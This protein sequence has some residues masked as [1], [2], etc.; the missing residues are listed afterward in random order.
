MTESTPLL[1]I[2]A[3][4]IGLAVGVAARQAGLQCV[5]LEKRNIVSTIERYPLG[6]TFFSTPERVEIGGLPFIAL[7]VT[8]RLLVRRAP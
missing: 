8:R 2:G 3:G 5:L 1:V 6:M 7:N 4:P